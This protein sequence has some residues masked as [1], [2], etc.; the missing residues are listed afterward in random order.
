VKAR[1]VAPDQWP[2]ASLASSRGNPRGEAAPHYRWIHL[3]THGFFAP[4]EIASALTASK[5]DKERGFGEFGQQGISGYH[6]GLLSRVALSGAQT[7]VAEFPPN[8]ASL[9]SPSKAAT[10]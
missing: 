6:P 5:E 8:A 10:L 3:T 1:P 9:L 2:E 7:Q 4:R